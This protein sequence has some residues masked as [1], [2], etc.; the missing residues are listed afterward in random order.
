MLS[1]Y[2]GG[3][4][5]VKFPVFGSNLKT[6]NAWDGWSEA[7][8]HCIIR[9][10]DRSENILLYFADTEHL[11]DKNQKRKKKEKTIHTT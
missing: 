2:G 4:N 5:K 9:I 8:T 6:F 7:N 3:Q 11:T 10:V 1:E